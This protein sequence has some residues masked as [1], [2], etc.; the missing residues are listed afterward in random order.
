MFERSK[1]LSITALGL[2]MSLSGCATLDSNQPL[3]TQQK[4]INCGM[5]VAGGAVLG[6]IVGNNVGDGDAGSGAVVGGVLGAGACGVWLAFENEKDKRRLLEAQLAAAQTGNAVTETWTGDDGRER[7]VSVATSAETQMVVASS[8]P[9]VVVDSE[10]VAPR[11]CRP[12]NT[13]VTVAGRSETL[14]EVY[15]RTD[16]GDWEPA[17]EQM[18]ALGS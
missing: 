12:M 17:A 10:P 16:S 13:T 3:T 6:A 8:T 4:I 11:I 15:C 18:V 5:M 14:N 9:T 2:A 7:T 1:I